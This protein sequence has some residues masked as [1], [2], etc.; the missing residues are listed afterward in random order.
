VTAD[1]ER[2]LM[3]RRAGGVE[4]RQIVLVTNWFEE[5]RAKLGGGSALPSFVSV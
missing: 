1:G 5:L 2:F 4:P 3:P